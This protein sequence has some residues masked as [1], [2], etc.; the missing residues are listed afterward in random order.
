MYCCS[1]DEGVTAI[2]TVLDALRACWPSYYK[3]SIVYFLGANRVGIQNLNPLT[4]GRTAEWKGA[5]IERP[6]APA[7]QSAIGGIRPEMLVTILVP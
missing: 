7:V 4:V 6:T 2:Y 1:A 3:A 5:I